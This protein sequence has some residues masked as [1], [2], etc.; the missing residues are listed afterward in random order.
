MFQRIS[1]LLLLFCSVQMLIANSPTVPKN[2]IENALMWK[3]SGNN[4]KQNSYLFGT[5]HAIPIDDYF[6]GKNTIKKFKECTN[7]VMEMDLVQLDEMKIATLSLLPEDKTIYDYLSPKEYDDLENFLINQFGMSKAMLEN[8]YGRLKPFFIDQFIMMSII[9]DNKKVY[10]EELNLL[11]NDYH[12]TKT[13]LETIEEQLQAIENI[14]LEIQYKNLVKSIDDYEV[15][16]SNY[17]K[18]VSAYKKQDLNFLNEQFEAEFSGDM[19]IYKT[20][21]L[22]QRNYKWV[23]KIIPMIEKEACFIAVG[24][25]HLSG[26]K[27]LIKLLQQLGYDVTPEKK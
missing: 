5:I 16:K 15:Q 6:L 8:V 7:L 21:L 10:E 4:L 2:N 9:G 26:E 25:G 23:D 13:G 22:D 19:N 1:I 12:L 27:G 18:M 11:A 17:I 14:P 3:I 20:T 24:A